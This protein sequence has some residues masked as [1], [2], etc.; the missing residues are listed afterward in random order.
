[1][2]SM[3]NCCPIAT[4]K[5]PGRR[6]NSHPYMAPFDLYRAKDKPFVI[7]CGN[8]HL[9]GTLCKAID[10]PELATWKVP[11]PRRAFAGQC[12]AR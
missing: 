12:D 2:P 5:A 11:R 9:F 4:G 3:F 7:C 8:N 6:G 10:R 1:M